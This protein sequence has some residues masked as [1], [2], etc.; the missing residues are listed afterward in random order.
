M[1]RNQWLLTIG[2]VVVVS[3]LAIACVAFLAVGMLANRNAGPVQS[4][5]VGQPPAQVTAAPEQAEQPP[6]TPQESPPAEQP[7]SSESAQPQAREE[8]GT[9]VQVGADPATLDPHLVTDFESATYIVEIFSGLV[10]LNPDLEIVP[11]LAASWDVDETGTVYTFHLRQDA[12]FHDGRPVTAQDF[13]WSFE[14]ALDPATLSTVSSLYLNDII[15][16]VDKLE[17]RADEVEG[18][19]VI[20]DHTLE[21][22]ID[23]PKAYFLAKLT[24]P[25]GFVLDQQNVESGGRTWTDKPNGTGAFRLREYRLGE[26]IVLERNRFYYG[27]P[28]PALQRVQF[29]LSGGSAMIMYESGDID[30]TPI[31]LAD[32]ERILDPTDPLHDE[33]TVVAPTLSTFYVGLNNSIPPFDDPKIRQAFNYAIDKDVLANVVL[34]RTRVPAEGVLPPRMPGYNPD[35]NIYDFD[36]EKAKQLIAE[37]KYGSVD[38]IPDITLST[39][40]AGSEPGT[41]ATAVIGMLEQNLGIEVSVELIESAVFLS[42]VGEGNYQMFVLGW[43]ADYPDPQDFLDILFYSQSANNH[44][45]YSNSDVDRLLEAARVEQDADKRMQLY[46]EIERMVVEDAPWI[47]LFHNAEYWLTKPYVQGMVYPPAVVPRLKY[48]WLEK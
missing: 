4:G 8:G 5:P 15:G 3:I 37:S 30:A 1:T 18:I 9:L 44:M 34:R 16:A 33:L 39:S 20:D 25:T 10:S 45:N 2:A 21:I 14:R 41:V 40:G 38:N 29:L 19:K 36:V 27:E 11:D 26:E 7:K 43:S 6:A 46:Q 47:P 17:G 31:G 35:L 32:I 12:Q 24:Y 48:I 28:K 42:E 13:K 23:A 22:T